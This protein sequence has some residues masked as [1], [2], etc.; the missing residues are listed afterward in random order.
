LFRFIFLILQIAII[1]S[2]SIF[3]INNSLNI[4]IELNDFIYSISSSYIILIL[5]FVFLILFLIQSFYFNTKFNIR[6]YKF[7]KLI[8]N[9][10]KGYNFFVSGV[11]ALANQDYKKAISDSK[12]I[13][14]YL[15][16]SPSLSL[17]LNSEIYKIEKKYDDLN[18]VY[19]E[20]L[21][22]KDTQ[23]LAYRGMMEQHLRSQD[24]HHAFIY[25]E[26]LFNKNPYTEKIYDALVGIIA[27]TNNWQ[28]LLI[29]TNRAFEK[30]IINKREFQDNKSIGFFEIAKIKQFSE[31]NESIGLLE[32]AL[33]LRK[34]FPPY[35]KLYVELLI[36]DKNYNLA[37]KYLKKMWIV[38]PH[39]EYKSMIKKLSSCLNES[40]IDLVKFIISNNTTKEISKILLIDA[41]IES[42]KWDLARNE[43]KT[44]LDLQPKKE[45]CLLMARIEAGDTGEMQKVNS[46]N[47]RSKNG[48][49][50]NAWVCLI[51]N[52]IQEEWSP[53]SRAGN[54]NSLVWKQPNMLD[55]FDNSNSSL[56]YD[57]K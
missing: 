34:N 8:D 4:S 33:N 41:A 19:E 14:K 18:A 36:K 43:I 38:N 2:L 13:S 55:R 54:F 37:K 28:Q 53:V 48:L 29:I 15:G 1:L 46:W 10:E 49:E 57:N 24:Y 52:Q 56:S 17:L 16:D 42:K 47:L 6:K 11:I 40:Y 35:I 51:S 27:K 25:G 9:K 22:N 45:V 20:M 3:V 39:N 12:K 31:I 30:K 5:L 23:N 32:K 21:K 26:K 7:N 44:L 50:K